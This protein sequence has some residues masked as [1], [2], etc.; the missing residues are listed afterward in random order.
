MFVVYPI[1]IPSYFA[2]KLIWQHGASLDE[3]KRLEGRA[4]AHDLLRKTNT[5]K[6]KVEEKAVTTM[7]ARIRGAQSRAQAANDGAQSSPPPSPPSTAVDPISPA[8]SSPAARPRAPS[9]QSTVDGAVGSGSLRQMLRRSTLGS[10]L[11]KTMMKSVA[12][13]EGARQLAREGRMGV[14]LPEAVL[15]LTEGYELRVYWFEVV[16][17]VRKLAL[18]GMP[19][20]FEMGSVPQL[21]FGLL[22][23]FFSFGA[24]MHLEPYA[25]DRDDTL[26][27]LCQA[28]TFFA[29]VSSII[30]QSVPPDSPANRNMGALL[31]LLTAL[32][33]AF[34]VLIEIQ[35][36]AEPEDSG[37]KKRKMIA[38]L[39]RAASQPIVRRMATKRNLLGQKQAEGEKGRRALMHAR[40]S[41]KHAV[42]VKTTR[43]WGD[44]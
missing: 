13:A 11:T 1:G 19:V 15:K 30:L 5:S 2:Y 39:V 42:S 4:K 17:C 26:S 9:A 18:T 25:D 35:S 29:L 34:A 21:V 31:V 43:T 6:I 14:Q 33:I 38:R 7:Q 10:S 16:E 24:Y 20:W 12:T 23:S 27:Q 36:D 32:P 8:S 44:N 28:Q 22:I 3:L 40:A 37:A 41:E